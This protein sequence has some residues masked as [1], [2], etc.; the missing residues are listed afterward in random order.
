M[1]LL[2]AISIENRAKIDPVDHG[3]VVERRA[4]ADHDRP[5]ERHGERGPPASVRKFLDRL[6]ELS[7]R[8]IFDSWSI[9]AGWKALI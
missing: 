9:R 6:A 5:S 3:S 1:A 2:P 7:V 4:C 8:L